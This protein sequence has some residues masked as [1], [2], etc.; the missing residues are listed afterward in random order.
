[1]AVVAGV[2]SDTRRRTLEAVCDT[3][4]PSVDVETDDVVLRDFYARGAS[5]LGIAGVN[6]ITPKGPGRSMIYQRMKR[7]RDVFNTPPL[8]PRKIKPLTRKNSS[9]EKAS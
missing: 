7:R 5:D 6:L 4:A 1:M 8:G 9:A 3:V 2:L